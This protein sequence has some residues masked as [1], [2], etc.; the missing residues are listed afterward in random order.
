MSVGR[1]AGVRLQKDWPH[2]P[3]CTF[4]IK[5]GLWR[6]HQPE[7]YCVS[8]QM[9]HEQCPALPSETCCQPPD[10]H[11]RQLLAA[12]IHVSSE[13]ELHL[14][15]PDGGVL[16]S[17]LLCSG[18]L[19]WGFATPL[20]PSLLCTFRPTPARLCQYNATVARTQRS[21]QSGHWIV[22]TLQ[23]SLIVVQSRFCRPAH[24]TDNKVKSCT[25]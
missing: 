16:S 18:A 24:L 2:Y 14:G 9:L 25:P 23:H 17:A 21:T 22:S 11:Q 1:T 4:N 6:T 3:I 15:K 7:F 19:L 13:D 20:S 10:M 8:K 12:A 5:V